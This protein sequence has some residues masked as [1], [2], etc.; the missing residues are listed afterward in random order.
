MRKDYAKEIY[1]TYLE[2]TYSKANILAEKEYQK[3]AKGYDANYSR[4]IPRNN[5]AM[6]LD[7]G[8]GTGT[9][10]W[11]LKKKGYTNFWGIDICY[12]YHNFFFLA[13]VL[14]IIAIR[15]SP[16]TKRRRTKALP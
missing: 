1:D 8:C 2:S 15:S 3:A 13:L 10:L 7:I 14:I 12:F 5:N 11:Y 16:K 9:F 6:I 4:F